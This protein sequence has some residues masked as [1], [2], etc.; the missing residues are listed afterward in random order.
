MEEA[1]KDFS[2][3]LDFCRRLQT[4]D[5][6]GDQSRRRLLWSSLRTFPLTRTTLRQRLLQ[7]LGEIKF[8]KET[9][10]AVERALYF[11][12]ATSGEVKLL[13]ISKGILQKD[14][15]RS[16]ARLRYLWVWTFV[17]IPWRAQERG[18]AY[19]ALLLFR[20]NFYLAL[21]EGFVPLVRTLQARL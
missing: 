13:E 18:L 1:A 15:E 14:F 3:V 19:L 21:V 5:L 6:S 8:A 16:R 4:W 17:L 7:T 10:A 11:P 9:L 12:F 2:T 20:W